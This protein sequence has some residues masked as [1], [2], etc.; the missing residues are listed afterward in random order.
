MG[1]YKSVKFQSAITEIDPTT[2]KGTKAKLAT[3]HI[4]P[5]PQIT[6]PQA[7][8]VIGRSTP[9]FTF[10]QDE[11]ECAPQAGHG[12]FCETRSLLGVKATVFPWNWYIAPGNGQIVCF[13]R[14]GMGRN[15]PYSFP[16][17]GGGRQLGN[18]DCPI[19][20]GDGLGKCRR[21]RLT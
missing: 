7:E 16:D 17:E 18:C 11:I 4:I 10:A 15:S 12:C 3:P 13:N 14:P 5:C 20:E 2:A 6:D 19:A 21:P 9:A 1:N 8:H